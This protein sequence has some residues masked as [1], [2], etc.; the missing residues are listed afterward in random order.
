MKRIGMQPNR[1]NIVMFIYIFLM[2][3]SLSQIILTCT[4]Q[5]DLYMMSTMYYIGPKNILS[6]KTHKFVQ[7]FWIATSHSVLCIEQQNRSEWTFH[8]PGQ[9]HLC[10]ISIDWYHLLCHSTLTQWIA[11][12]TDGISIQVAC[13]QPM[14]AKKRN[15]VKLAWFKCPQHV[16][17]Q[18]QWWS[19]FITHLRI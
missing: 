8:L 18:G 10:I 1:R 17:I 13:I 3:H 6:V 12:Y 15:Q 7:K 11:L 19:I 2:Y 9:V 14:G 4:G 16:L 5:S